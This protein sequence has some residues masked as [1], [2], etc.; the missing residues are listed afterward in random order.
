MHFYDPV[1]PSSPL[2]SAGITS[3]STYTR[4]PAGP[5]RE[6]KK[7][8]SGPWNI[9]ET[10]YFLKGHFFCFLFCEEAKEKKGR[11]VRANTPSGQD[12]D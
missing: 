10:A 9:S 6:K 2:E 12:G 8:K 11:P 1:M 7:K 5:L 3:S 4:G